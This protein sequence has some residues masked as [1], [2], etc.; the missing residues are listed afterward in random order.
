MSEGVERGVTR[1]EAMA[2]EG[3]GGELKESGRKIG[4]AAVGR[5]ALIVA[6]D[7]PAGAGKSTLLRSLN[8]L[9][10]LIPGL[11]V[12]GDVML[13]GESIYGAGVDEIVDRQVKLVTVLH[14]TPPSVEMG[15]R[16]D[17]VRN[18]T[19]VKSEDGVVVGYQV[20]LTTALLKICGLVANSIVVFEESMIGSPVPLYE[21][22]TE[23]GRAHV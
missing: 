23:I 1:S 13:H 15:T 9:T 4:P 2:A 12:S 7:G 10:D 6:I 11:R 21:S 19:V 3:S 22:R 20:A 5:T 18:P 16:D 17:P 14:P 8:R